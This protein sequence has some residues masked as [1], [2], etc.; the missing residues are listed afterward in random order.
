MTSA[1]DPDDLSVVDELLE[2]LDAE[3]AESLRPVLAELRGLAESEPVLPNRRLASLL[4]AAPG[5]SAAA[6]TSAHEQPSAD[7]QRPEARHEAAPAT[8]VDLEAVRSTRSPSRRRRGRPATTA[9]IIAIAAGAASAGAAA[10]AQGGFHLWPGS[11]TNAVDNAPS[12]APST[13]GTGQASLPARV[14]PAVPAPG[15]SSAPEGTQAP[16]TVAPASA[17]PASPVTPSAPA[18]AGSVPA[19]PLPQLPL[20]PPSLAPSAVPTMPHLPPAPTPPS[21]LSGLLPKLP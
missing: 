13:A 10:A 6:L 11:T 8:V 3:D 18:P 15:S 17:R 5:P 2:G 9:L 16:A 12:Q 21:L 7:E 14:A 20:S 19:V 4:A 1:F